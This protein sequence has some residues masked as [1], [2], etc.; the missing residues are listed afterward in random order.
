MAKTLEEHY[1][2]LEDS[3]KVKQYQAA[4]AASIRPEHVVLDLGCGTGLLGLM[5]LRAG[6][7]K[8]Y[9][10]EEGPIIEAA[11]RTIA[12]TGFADKAVFLQANSYQLSLPEQVDVVICDHVG[13]F[14]FDYGILGLLA[15]AKQRFLKP[16][17][18]SIPERIELNLAP[19]ESESCRN[20]VG[21]WR[22]GDIPEEYSW[23]GTPAANT[24]HGVQL[25]ATDLLATPSAVAN[26]EL[27]PEAPPFM[28]WTVEF[29]STRDG[30]LDGVAGW[31]DCCLRGDIHMTNAPTDSTALDRPQAYLPLEK[32]VAVREGDLIRATIMVRHQDETIGWLIELP[33]TGERFAQTTF[34]GLLLDSDTLAQSR[35]NRVARLNDRGRA[36]QIVLS[37][38]DGQRT[39]SEVQELVLRDHPDLLPSASAIAV[40]INRVLAWDT[41][42]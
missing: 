6:A 42:E 36:R 23:M 15:D 9:F 31:F 29:S 22:S 12:E 39:V 40:F 17:G 24:K 7:H 41:S 34:N 27:G 4:V 38:C 20:I 35:P 28:S 25:A 3:A 1:G 21:R 10:V 2:Y 19:V 32:P 8:V 37:Y 26:L 33:R 11:R 16:D 14:G 5:A 13:Y 30:T 18:F